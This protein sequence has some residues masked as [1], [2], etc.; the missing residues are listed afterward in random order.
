MRFI[1]SSFDEAFHE[2]E[3]EKPAVYN[4]S[5]T[6][7]A[8]ACGLGRSPWRCKAK[9][10]EC[11]DVGRVVCVCVCEMKVVFEIER[12]VRGISSQSQ[13]NKSTM[14]GVRRSK[15]AVL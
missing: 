11:Y 12:R 10:Q 15:N 14:A 3:I 8:Q 9:K 4:V 6:T 1:R 7:Q 13:P 5:N 2:R